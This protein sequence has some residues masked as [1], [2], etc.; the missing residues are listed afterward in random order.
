MEIQKSGKVIAIVA[1][2]FT[3]AG[4]SLGF[5]AY[6][7]TLNILPLMPML[8]LMLILGILVFQLLTVL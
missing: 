3:V 7:T 1:L 6:S 5:A 2:L 4:L 8:N